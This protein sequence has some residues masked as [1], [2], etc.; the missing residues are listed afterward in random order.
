MLQLAWETENDPDRVRNAPTR[1]R[2][3]GRTR[4][5][6]NRGEGF[7]MGQAS[8][9]IYALG[10]AR[11]DLARC[12]ARPPVI[13]VGQSATGNRET[14]SRTSCLAVVSDRIHRS[15][16]VPCAYSW[17]SL[18]LPQPSGKTGALLARRS[19]LVIGGAG[20]PIALGGVHKPVSYTHLTLP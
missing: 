3:A 17:S 4:P 15:V 12:L 9:D 10:L 1:R 19:R 16:S 6:N 7:A 18:Q 14:G 20:R 11:G 2:S 5:A 13:R 8:D